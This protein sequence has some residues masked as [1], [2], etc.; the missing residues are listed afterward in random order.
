[1]SLLVENLSSGYGKTKVLWNVSFEVKAGSIACLLGLNGAGK[2]TL[3]KTIMGLL[4]IQ[5]GDIRFEGE[6]LKSKKPHSIAKKGIAY[7]PQDTALFP[8]LTVEENLQV[9][10]RRRNGFES[11]LKR[12]LEPF[13]V[14]SERLTQRA[15]SLSGGEQK[16]LFVARA[17]LVSPRLMLLDEISEGVQPIS[18]ERILGILEGLNQQEKTT[19]FLVEQNIRFALRLAND[20]LVMKQGRIVL[21]GTGPSSKEREEI[22]KILAL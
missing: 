18:L 8:D 5:E 1:M 12:T 9:A 22:E 16:M 17:I 14:L 3:L 19:I 11:A 10:Y 6:S 13:P 21:Q 4:P 2:S 20:Y 7:S 15:S